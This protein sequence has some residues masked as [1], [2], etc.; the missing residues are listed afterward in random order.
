MHLAVSAHTYGL[1]AQSALV[2][3]IARSKTLDGQFDPLAPVTIVVPSSLAGYHIRRSLGR[4]PGGMVNVQVRPLQALLELIGSTALIA[5]GR[6]PLPDVRRYEAIRSVAETGPSV[7]GDVPIEGGVLRTLTQRFT[8][9]DDC[10]RAQLDTL[11]GQG[12]IPAYLVDRYDA[13]RAQTE[14]FYTHRDLADSAIE[15][16]QQRPNVLRDIGSV[17]VYLPGRP[18]LGRPRIPASARRSHPRSR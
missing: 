6:R 4:R 9:F 12:G 14:D 8:E 18:E 5:A 16:L 1:E 11:A 17:I 3:S 7:F 10:D 15:A 13:Y 2:E